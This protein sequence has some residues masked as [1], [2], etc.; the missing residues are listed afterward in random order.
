MDLLEREYQEE[1]LSHEEEFIQ[2][3]PDGEGY[4][5]PGPSDPHKRKAFCVRHLGV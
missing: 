2:S 1:I 4:E 5:S 3:Q